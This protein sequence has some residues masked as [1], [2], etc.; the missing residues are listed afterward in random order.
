LVGAA[1]AGIAGLAATIGVERA[2]VTA[3][4]AVAGGGLAATSAGA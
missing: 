3:H 4:R 1:L 2:A